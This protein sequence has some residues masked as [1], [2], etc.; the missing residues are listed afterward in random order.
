MAAQELGHYVSGFMKRLIIRPSYPEDVDFQ[1]NHYKELCSH[2]EENMQRYVPNERTT[3]ITLV[4]LKHVNRT[5]SE[6]MKHTDCRRVCQKVAP[7]I[8][9]SV[10]HPSVQDLDAIP[11]ITHPKLMD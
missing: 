10:V 6:L 7:L 11:S 2:L 8:L 5:Y 1:Y 9:K 4:L 3:E